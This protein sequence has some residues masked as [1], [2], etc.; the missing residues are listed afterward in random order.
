[1]NTIIGNKY[2][3]KLIKTNYHNKKNMIKLENKLY[4]V[5]S[6]HNYKIVYKGKIESFRLR[7]DNSI[8]YFKI[9]RLKI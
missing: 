9:P 7:I 3:A 4:Y 5:N 1:M 6:Y 2:G 8:E